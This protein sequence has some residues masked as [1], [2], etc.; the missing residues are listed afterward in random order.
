MKAVS[1]IAKLLGPLGLALL[2]AGCLVSG[3]FTVVIFI[4]NQT[5]DDNHPNGF[6]HYVVDLSEEEDWDDHKDDIENIDIIGFDLWVTNMRNT[7]TTFNAWVDDYGD[8][9]ITDPALLDGETT[10]IL[11]DLAITAGPNVVTHISY[12]ESLGHLTNVAVLKAFVKG[13]Q[14]R[15][16]GRSEGTPTIGDDYILDSVRVV[17]TFTAKGG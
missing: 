3:T 8:A 16:Y 12:A 5:L 9:Q 11:Q 15:L 2:V 6:Y 14:F 4:D 7:A 13:G 17:V 1:S 10:P